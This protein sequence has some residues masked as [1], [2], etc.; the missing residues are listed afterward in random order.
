MSSASDAKYNE[1]VCAVGFDDN[2]CGVVCLF[3]VSQVEVLLG[4]FYTP[5]FGL[6][7]SAPSITPSSIAGI[8]LS[9]LGVMSLVALGL[10]CLVDRDHCYR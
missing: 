1:P 4:S 8:V 10:Y 3:E 6:L 9:L 2:I 5:V 7:V